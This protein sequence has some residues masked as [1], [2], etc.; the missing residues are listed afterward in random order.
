MS[1]SPAYLA[2][3]AAAVAMAEPPVP[4]LIVDP[5]PEDVLLTQWRRLYDACRDG[6]TPQCDPIVYRIVGLTR[7][8]GPTP[9]QKVPLVLL[10]NDI[11]QSIMDATGIDYD[12]PGSEIVEDLI[13][14]NRT[15]L[16]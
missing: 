4:Y 10:F 6:W 8:V 5:T 1:D 9:W 14:H 3:R 16:G 2:A 13:A 12:S 11:Y 15:G 7:V